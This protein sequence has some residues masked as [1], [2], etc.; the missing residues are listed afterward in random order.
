MKML[1]QLSKEVPNRDE[2]VKHIRLNCYKIFVFTSI[3]PHKLFC[4]DLTKIHSFPAWFHV[5]SKKKMESTKE[6]KSVIEQYGYRYYEK[7]TGLP[8][9][10]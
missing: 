7:A 2:I 10:W 4:F 8:N 5:D 3:R 6:A 1:H 9:I